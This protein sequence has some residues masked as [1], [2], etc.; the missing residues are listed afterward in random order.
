MSEEIT[1]T[2]TYKDKM[3]SL[4]AAMNKLFNEPQKRGDKWAEAPVSVIVMAQHIIKK[5]HRR[6]TE[7]R[8]GFLL[9][10]EPSTS[11][12]K[13]VRAKANTV[14]EKL[15]ILLDLDFIIWLD[16]G[17]WGDLEEARREAVIDHELCHCDYNG[18]K[19][20]IRAHDIEEFSEIVERRGL[21]NSG[22]LDFGEK[23][24]RARQIEMFPA[25]DSHVVAIDP[26]SVGEAFE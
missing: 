23:I 7:A 18:V 24:E 9:R 25:G 15:K 14:P 26:D 2:L 8:I 21:W 5:Y 19:Y 11:Q 1:T 4:D 10:T 3:I 17:I 13:R 16:E 20:S 22:L 6:L 12:G